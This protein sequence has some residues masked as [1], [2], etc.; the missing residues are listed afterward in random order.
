VTCA[1]GYLFC[2]DEV[3]GN[4]HIGE[5]SP[6]G[7]KETSVIKLPKKSKIR[8]ANGRIW[9]HPVIANGKLFLRD[10]DLLF[11]FDVKE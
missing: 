8:S 1:G 5:A 6:N 3:T 11:C 10:Q 9:T 2:Y 7:W 4:V